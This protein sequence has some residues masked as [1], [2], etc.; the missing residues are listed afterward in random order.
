M[1]NTATATEQTVD[2]YQPRKITLTRTI[3]GKEVEFVHQT[4]QLTDQIWIDFNKTLN[5]RRVLENK[6]LVYKEDSEKAVREA[7]KALVPTVPQGY[8]PFFKQELTQENYLQLIPFEDQKT[9][10]EEVFA[11]DANESEDQEFF[12]DAEGV[13]LFDVDAPINGEVESFQIGLNPKTKGAQKLYKE[14]TELNTA[15]A[16]RFRNPEIPASVDFAKLSSL[17]RSLVNTDFNLPIWMQIGLMNI[18]FVQ[19]AQSEAKN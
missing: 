1:E 12:F 17:Y 4:T 16:K 18:Y 7:Y 10:L 19:Y 8:A 13:V 11:F 6:K 3:K 2:F 15:N 5:P 14:A 9:V